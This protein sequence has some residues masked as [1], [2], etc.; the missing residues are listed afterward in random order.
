MTPWSGACDEK[1]TGIQL[2]KR[3]WS[4]I[5]CFIRK[6]VYVRALLLLVTGRIHADHVLFPDSVKLSDK[7]GGR[8]FERLPNIIKPICRWILGIKVIAPLSYPAY[9]Q[10]Y[11]VKWHKIYDRQPNDIPPPTFH[12]SLTANI[13]SKN[14]VAEFPEAGVLELDAPHLIGATLFS[15]E[16]HLLT[17]SDG[18]FT[19]TF[20]RT[21]SVSV[22]FVRW[23][24]F[25]AKFL[26]GVSLV[27]IANEYNSGNYGHFVLD[28]LPRVE[29]FK[30]AGFSFSDVDHVVAYSTRLRSA[31]FLMERVGIPLEK[32][33]SPANLKLETALVPS[34]PGAPR[35]Y[36]YWTPRFLRRELLPHSFP[37]HSRRIYVV[38]DGYTRN[39]TNESEVRKLLIRHGFEMIDPTQ[40]ANED[41][42]RKFGEASLIV[43]AHGAGLA[44]IALCPPGAK[45]LELVPSD[46]VQPYYY[47]LANAAD[48]EYHCLICPSVNERGENAWGPSPYDFHVNET[49]L[50]GALDSLINRD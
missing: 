37:I 21:P 46:H 6:S 9:A 28:V 42:V 25:R 32:I 17:A 13:A 14:V 2:V 33:R 45:I 20:D 12:G 8:A 43:G 5:Y 50:V 47:T 11:K 41:L 31:K 44:D 35:N 10:M 24:R 3:L 22:N 15:R 40:M 38:R 1:A 29:L 19:P 36:P 18:A 48:L 4:I 7:R 26:K 16:G 27:L 39:A 30:K 34:F 23:S 49:E